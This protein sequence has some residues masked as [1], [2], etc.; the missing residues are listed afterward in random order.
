MTPMADSCFMPKPYSTDLRERVIAALKIKPHQEVAQE[1]AIS[2]RTVF[3]WDARQKERGNVTPDA[4]GGGR[5]AKLTARQKAKVFAEVERQP[6]IT[7]E[8]LRLRLSLPVGITTIFNLLE[9]ENF[10][11]KKRRSTPGSAPFRKSG[12]KSASSTGPSEGSS[13]SV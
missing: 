6:D 12:R 2:R 3:Y 7:L 13:R 5:P 9:R 8:E 10:S 1:F 11:F 4:W